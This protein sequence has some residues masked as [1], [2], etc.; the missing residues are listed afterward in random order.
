MA[1]FA[2]DTAKR[3]YTYQNFAGQI[4][5][6]ESFLVIGASHYRDRFQGQFR[7]GDLPVSNWLSA[8]SWLSASQLDLIALD[9]LRH[10]ECSLGFQ[11]T[12]SHALD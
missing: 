9:H 2:L 5:L 4:E 6:T 10:D 3:D 7:R 8:T 11:V 12:H 1:Q